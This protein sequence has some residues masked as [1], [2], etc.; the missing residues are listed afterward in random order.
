MKKLLVIVGATATG[1]S[2]LAIKIAKKFNGEIISADSRQI[3]RNL[4]IG[5]G[6][7]TKQEQKQVKH[8]MINIAS[9]KKQ[10]TVAQY[11]QQANKIIKKI[12]QQQK[13][14]IICGGSPL[15][16]ISVI[17]GLQ[18]PKIKTNPK[19]RAQLA[20]RP[21]TDLWQELKKLDPVRANN[22][23]SNNKRRII[24]ALEIIY[25][26]EKPIQPLKKQPLTSDILILS[27]QKSKEE[28]KHLIK[29]RLDKR[30]KQGM[31]KEVKKLKKQNISSKRLY[32]LGLEYRY[33]NLYL[34]KKISYQEMY[35]TLYKKIIDFAKR[36]L[37]WFKKFP[38]VQYINNDKQ[39][40]KIVK[41]WL[42]KP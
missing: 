23:D 12:W 4:D 5:T 1:K 2:N 35:D 18:F 9:V 11:T 10:Y 16:V 41:R 20:A 33:I 24:R 40:I 6:K 7:I 14:P 32:D 31:I 3:Y 19:L 13:L 25:T 34:D 21:L 15:Y 30:L 26:T 42:S 37:T 27:T 29:T 38:N 8:Y 17:E 39:A 22:I 28:I 36:Q